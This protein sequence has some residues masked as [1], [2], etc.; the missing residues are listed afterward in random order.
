[1][2]NSYIIESLERYLRK[3]IESHPNTPITYGSEFRSTGHII[4]LILHH[5]DNSEIMYI[6]KKGS[7]NPL[8]SIDDNENK[9]YLNTMIQRVNQT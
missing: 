8:K 2:Q 7:I 6:I 1:M 9:Q 3:F 4:S 5:K